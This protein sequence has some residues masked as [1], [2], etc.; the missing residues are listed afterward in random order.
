MKAFPR[1][2]EVKTMKVRHI[3]VESELGIKGKGRYSDHR[4]IGDIEAECKK[5]GLLQNVGFDG[6]GREFRTN[7]ISVRSLNQV[8][9]HKYLVEYYDVLKNNTK[10][11]ESGGTHLHI[12]ILNKDHENLESNATAMAIAF[13]K[14]FQKISG[15]RSGWA[16]RYKSSMAL[17]TLDKVRK[18]LESVKR[19]DGSRAYSVK[20][21]MLNPTY[22]QTFEFRGPKGSN[23]CKEILAWVEFLNNITKICN[24]KSVEGV[25]FKE[26]LKGKR[27]EAYVRSL[28]GWRKLTKKE[29]EH[30]FDGDNLNN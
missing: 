6:G 19:N 30:K 10:V 23:D 28:K 4:D 3:G 21:Y 25:E 22:H 13:Y 7:P 12:S 27:I 1:D 5:R 29:L 18:D 9:G 14:Q 16:G 17:N 24:R 20:G 2:V 26:L 15:R 11:L 8:R